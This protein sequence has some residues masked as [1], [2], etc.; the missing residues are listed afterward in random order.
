[1]SVPDG[2][3]DRDELSVLVFHL[4]S[5]SMR[6]LI[7]LGVFIV[8]TVFVVVVLFGCG[9]TGETPITTPDNGRC[10]IES[11]DPLVS[12]TC[13]KTDKVSYCNLRPTGVRGVYHCSGISDDCD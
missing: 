10:C 6:E 13:V 11:G 3:I 2:W 1:M 12:D 8:Y 7:W 4:M 5:H 9:S